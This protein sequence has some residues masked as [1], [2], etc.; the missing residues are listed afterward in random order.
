MMLYRQGDGTFMHEKLP[1]AHLLE[2]SPD[3]PC[4]Q[5]GKRFK[6]MVDTHGFVKVQE[7]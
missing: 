1:G 2:T 6:V 5:V 4:S 7:L 3:K